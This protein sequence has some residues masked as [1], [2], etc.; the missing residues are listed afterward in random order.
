MNGAR[1]GGGTRITPLPVQSV[2][3]AVADVVPTQVQRPSN[4]MLWPDCDVIAG[5]HWALVMLCN[6]T[7]V[8]R[9][10]YDCQNDPPEGMMTRARANFSV[11]DL[12]LPPPEPEP[13]VLGDIDNPPVVTP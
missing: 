2:I 5:D 3:Q 1:L 12:E 9:V 13:V 7:E 8:S 11:V 6:D 4:V 10:D